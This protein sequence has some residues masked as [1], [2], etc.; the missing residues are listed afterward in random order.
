MTDKLIDPK[1]FDGRGEE[2]IGVHTGLHA[3]GIELEEGLNTS[4]KRNYCA[5]CKRN[6]HCYV[7]INKKTKEAIIHKTC[8]NDD[9]E[10]KCKT[11]YSCRKCGYLHP[12]GTKCNYV[13]PEPNFSPESDAVFEK[14]MKD[15]NKDNDKKKSSIP[16]TK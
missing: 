11:H 9:C 6:I 7:K 13:E 8:R 2:T 3:S 12:Y 4:T 1:D 14:L 5:N 16:K 10:C 15:W